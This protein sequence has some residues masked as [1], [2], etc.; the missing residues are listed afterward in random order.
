[1]TQITWRRWQNGPPEMECKGRITR[2]RAGQSRDGEFSMDNV[3][4]GC[5]A[6]WLAGGYK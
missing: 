3:D 1:M 4:M 5:G 6:I 2:L